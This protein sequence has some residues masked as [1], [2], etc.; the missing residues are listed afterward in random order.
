M[1]PT[2]QTIAMIKTANTKYAAW[3]RVNDFYG[4]KDYAIFQKFKIK[5]QIMRNMGYSYVVDALN[6]L[7]SQPGLVVRLFESTQKNALGFYQIWLNISGGWKEVL[8][9]DHIPIFCNKGKTKAQFYFTNPSSDPQNREIWYLL[10]EKALA[11]VYGSYKGLY[12]GSE[13]GLLRDLTGAP[14]SDYQVTHI[15]K[16]QKVTQREAEHINNL[17]LKLNKNLKK[18]YAM[19]VKPR[20]PSPLEAKRNILLNVFNKKYF[21]GDG[22]YSSHSYAILAARS[23]RTQDGKVTHLIRLRTPWLNERWTGDWG[24]NKE[25]LWTDSLKKSLN[26]YP[27]KDG[28]SEFWIPIRDFMHYFDIVNV[29][30]A[31]PGYVCNSV[32]LKFPKKRFPRAAIRFH[33]P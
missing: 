28:Y 3:Y 19:S 33:C 18:G 24:A 4:E 6:T 22:I 12:A 30:K 26:F 9:D 8:I 10:L 27:E 32:K 15:D 23:I 31:I 1:P 5:D 21:L 25:E 17:W 11:K 2:E 13:A 29:V 20:K 7:S 14:V 16:L